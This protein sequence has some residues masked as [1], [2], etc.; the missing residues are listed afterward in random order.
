MNYYNR[1]I[2]FL[3][4]FITLPGYAAVDLELTQ[5]AS[6]AIPVA[7]IPFGGNATSADLLDIAAIVNAD[8][9]NS[10][11]FRLLDRAKMQEKPQSM[12]EVKAK[13]WQDLTMDNLVIG[14]LKQAAD[15]RYQVNFQLLDI[16]GG[17]KG[18]GTA[19]PSVLLSKEFSVPGPGMRKLAHHISDLVY[20][21][22]TGERGVFATHIAYVVVEKAHNIPVR[23]RLE[24]SDADGYDPRNVLVSKQ[25][26]MSPAWSPDGRKIAYV[27][28]EKNHAGIYIQDIATGSRRLATDYPGING[29]PAWSPDGTKLAVVLSKGGTPNIYTLDVESNNLI[30]RTTG[31][32]IDTEPSWSPDGKALIFTSTRSGGP[33]IYRVDLDNGATQRVTYDGNYNASGS[34]TP[35]GKNIVMLHQ[36]NGAYHIALQNLQTGKIDILTE[37]SADQSPSVA[38]NGSMVLF[39]TKSG[40]RQVLGMVST[41]ARVALRL[42]AKDGDVREPDWSPL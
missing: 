3:L 22:L 17:K 20:E 1:L 38:P 39:A 40:P 12:E 29:A 8:L 31:S 24:I 34:F 2:C 25:P 26:I 32:S 42:P 23:Y 7:I 15:G 11:R 30:Q 28:F 33:Q 37:S 10:G 36:Q 19:Q 18:S 9:Q 14:T 4:F 21:K 6:G 27:S 41:D 5:G 35:D 16:Y 13:T